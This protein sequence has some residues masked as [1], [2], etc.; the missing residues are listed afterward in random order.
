MKKLLLSLATAIFGIT[1]TMAAD[2]TVDFANATGLPSAES[3][4]PEVVTINNVS[5]TFVNCKAG[6][7]NNNTYV[8]LTG[9]KTPKGYVEFSLPIN[10]ESFTITTGVGMSTAVTV[11]VTAG[12]ES[13]ETN[14]A[15]EVKDADF[16]FKLPTDCQA[17]GTVCRIQVSNTKNAQIQKIVFKEAT[18]GTVDPDPAP[19][20]LG[21]IMM[22]GQAVADITVEPETQIVFSSE[23]ATAIDVTVSEDNTLGDIAEGNNI[24]WTAP[25]VEGVYN[26]TVSATDDIDLKEASLVVTVKSKETP[27][28]SGWFRISSMSDLTV[29]DRYIIA[30][31]CGGTNFKEDLAISTE[32]NN[33]NRKTTG[34]TLNEDKSQILNPS[35]SVMTFVLEQ[36]GNDYLW[37]TENY[38]VTA[39]SYLYG[40]TGT[41]ANNRLQCGN[42]TT[43]NL[44]RRNTS[45]SFDDKGNAVITFVNCAKNNSKYV[46][47]FND[48]AA[49]SGGNCFNSYA[50]SN[51]NYLPIVLYKFYSAPESAKVYFHGTTDEV[52]ESI[53]LGGSE[54]KVHFAAAEGVNIFVKFE[55]AG[56]T[57]A[58]ADNAAEYEGFEPYNG[59]GFT[60]NVAGT[61]KHYTEKDGLKSPVSSITVTGTSTAI[62]EIDAAAKVNAEWFDLQ[63]RRVAS[64][65]KGRVYIVKEGSTTSKRAL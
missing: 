59:E 17:A 38:T 34:I 6:V 36:D 65:V 52:G 57:E 35:A 37:K 14:K 20:E 41:A 60:L 50:A 56:A 43:T 49:G 24:T 40:F 3:P 42:P 9:N 26:V 61:L 51:K 29:G 28:E 2:V 44:N 25:A 1:S 33:N 47:Y 54:K 63:G 31:I 46:I 4:N 62:N 16:E 23:N 39:E 12:A 22:N 11:N 7:Y 19:T 18:G 21:E 5:L 15:L 27:S 55:P 58:Q 64:P 8:Q 48:S 53:D 10:S 32:T 45:V 13:I 30:K